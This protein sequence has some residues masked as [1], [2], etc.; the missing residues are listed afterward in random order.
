M[1]S[2]VV[3]GGAL[4]LAVVLAAWGPILGF[5][6]TDVDT[7]ALIASGRVA[8]AADLAQLLGQ[9]TM[10]GRMPN[11]SFYR[12]A[13]SL[14]FGFDWALWGLR[15]VGYH[16]TD[17]LLHLAAVLLL[18]R[19]LAKIW[20]GSYSQGSFEARNSGRLAL[21]SAALFAVHPLH[22]A[23][24]PAI[25]RRAE[26][27]V[28]VCLLAC[29]LAFR[30]RLHDGG[31]VSAAVATVA[32]L[33]GVAAKESGLVIPI[34]ALLFGACF[35]P[36]DTVR[37]RMSRTLR[38]ATSM[39]VVSITY[40]VV[41]GLVLGGL[42]GY[43][44]AGFGLARRVS[45]SMLHHILGLGAP[46]ASHLW[47]QA[48]EWLR[49]HPLMVAAGVIGLVAVL[50]W[51][52]R[53]VDLGGPRFRTAVFL[54]VG[55]VV[56]AAVHLPV[57]MV[58]RYLYVSAAWFSALLVW[59]AAR[60]L[61]IGVESPVYRVVGRLAGAVATTLVASLVITSPLI[62]SGPMEEWRLAGDV[63]A[64]SRDGTARVVEGMSE[65]RTLVFVGFPYLVRT[66]HALPFAPVLLEHS[67]QGWLD[68]RFP[69]HGHRAVGTSYLELDLREWTDRSG[70]LPT[71]VSVAASA[72]GMIHHRVLAAGDATRFPWRRI[73]GPQ[74]EGRLYRIE[75]PQRGKEVGVR[76]LEQGWQLDPVFVVYLVDR[77][78]AR[79]GVGWTLD[80][81]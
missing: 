54:L 76:I 15:P 50:G 74:Y 27:L 36:G 72:D 75:G 30:R 56:V 28:A 24:V 55:I 62:R 21:V 42:G 67:L 64:S 16:L 12:P 14:S 39:I 47:G 8:S 13:T 58:P 5:D 71:L 33:V 66:E 59:I 60:G 78:E 25:A 32:C 18:W 52:F 43:L 80:S 69:G 29:L 77:V 81:G 35:A 68:L 1:T 37:E 34:H 46:G 51:L 9:P 49:G 31:A 61:L 11:A 70:A 20:S 2:R 63:G 45:Y 23:I 53:S 38:P 40:L 79:S 65:G 41:R 19:L 3:I 44:T 4:L 57:V 17:L 6:F 48:D 7:F 10:A 26:L 73:Y 22:V